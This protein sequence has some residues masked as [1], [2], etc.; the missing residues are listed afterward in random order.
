MGLGSNMSNSSVNIN[1]KLRTTLRR[2]SEFDADDKLLTIFADSR[3]KQWRDLVP[4]ANTPKDRVQAV[5]ATFQDRYTSSRENALFLLLHVLADNYEPEDMLHHELR[6]MASE[7]EVSLQVPK[8][9]ANTAYTTTLT[10][11]Q[12]TEI[13]PFSQLLILQVSRGYL[14]VQIHWL[15]LVTLVVA[16]VLFTG[17]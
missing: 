16:I 6:E 7:L 1:S 17:L 3:V 8:V 14:E 9:T 10:P 2:C 11:Q 4:R 13:A 12:C 5:I 15:L